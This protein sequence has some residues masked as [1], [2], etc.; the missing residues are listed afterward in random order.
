M[1]TRWAYAVPLA[2]AVF[3]MSFDVT[4]HALSNNYY[5]TLHHHYHQ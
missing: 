1:G 4:F 2:A 3:S 5:E